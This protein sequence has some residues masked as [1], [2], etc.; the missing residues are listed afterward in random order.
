MRFKKEHIV[1]AVSLRVIGLSISQV[2]NHMWQHHGVKV[3]EKTVRDW[4]KKYSR[5]IRKFTDKLKPKLKGNIHSDEVIVKV[6]KKKAYYWGSKDRKT[7]FKIAGVLTE[8]RDYEKGTKKLFQKIKDKCYDEIKQKKEEGIP[9]KFISDKLGHYK[10]A[11]N[12]FFLH[13]AEL[14]HG[15][16]IACKKYGL[17][18]NNNCMERDNERIK[19]RYKTMRGFKDFDD[20]E[21]TLSLIDDC[22]NFVNPHMSLNGRTPAE[23]AG[24]DLNLGRNKLL[25]LIFF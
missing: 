2:V 10:K 4:V 24:L 23:E 19:Q 20:A 14:A 12:K 9:I 3:D 13:V 25:H 8:G 17:E 16:P 15:V 11:F 18:H 5:L 6:R 21:E 7:K 1:E 22:Y